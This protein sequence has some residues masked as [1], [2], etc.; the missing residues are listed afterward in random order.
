M[1]IAVQVAFVM[2]SRPLQAVAVFAREIM[3]KILVVV[4]AAVIVAVTVA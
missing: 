2:A 1:G 4:I 3:V